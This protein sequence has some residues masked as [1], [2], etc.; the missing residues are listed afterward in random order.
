MEKSVRV[1]E[2]EYS[3]KMAELNRGFE[4]C[5]SRLGMNNI[6]TRATQKAVANSFNGMELK[7][8]EVG[9]TAIRI[10]KYKYQLYLMIF[11]IA[12]CKANNWNQYI[13]SD[14]APRQHST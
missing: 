2:R 7:M 6:L 4:V 13:W 3:K 10:G 1:S 12:M 5:L 9:R 11:D 8:N 14:N